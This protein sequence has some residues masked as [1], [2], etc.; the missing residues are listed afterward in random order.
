MTPGTYETKEVIPITRHIVMIARHLVVFGSARGLAA[1]ILPRKKHDYINAN[2][3]SV[4]V[5]SCQVGNM[6]MCQSYSTVSSKTRC[7]GV[8]PC[9]INNNIIYVS[10]PLNRFLPAFGGGLLYASMVFR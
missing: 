9:A 4:G 7:G 6:S 8:T 5:S 10:V 3:K 2:T 1:N